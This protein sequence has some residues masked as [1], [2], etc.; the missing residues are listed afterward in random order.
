MS[1]K[2]KCPCILLLLLKKYDDKKKTKTY[3]LLYSTVYKNL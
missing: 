3:L 2:M 1:M